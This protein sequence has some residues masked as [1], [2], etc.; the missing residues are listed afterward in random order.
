MRVS[1]VRLGD[2]EDERE[3]GGGD[4]DGEVGLAVVG[5]GDTL[6][7]PDTVR[8]QVSVVQQ[9]VSPDIEK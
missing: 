7:T 2:V 5:A 8:V 1:H 4:G 3:T 9:Q 6:H